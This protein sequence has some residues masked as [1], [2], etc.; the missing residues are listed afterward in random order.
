[1]YYFLIP[2]LML[3]AFHADMWE[4]LT[5]KQQDESRL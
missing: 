5:Q 4:A 1:M 3:H 2:K